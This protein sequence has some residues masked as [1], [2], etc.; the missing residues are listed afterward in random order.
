LVAGR[1]FISHH[2]PDCHSQ[3]NEHQDGCDEHGCDKHPRS[4]F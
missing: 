1:V 3:H 4:S 2:Q